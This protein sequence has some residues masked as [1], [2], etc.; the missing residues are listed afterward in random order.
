MSKPRPVRYLKTSAEIIRL[1]VTQY[2][3]FPRSLRNV[4][5]LPHEPKTR[6]HQAI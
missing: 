6:A 2:F 3:R 1:V 4:E 5:D